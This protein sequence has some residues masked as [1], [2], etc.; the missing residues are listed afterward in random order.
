MASARLIGETAGPATSDAK[1]MTV[2]T[3]HIRTV[4]PKTRWK[5][6]QCTAGAQ[7]FQVLLSVELSQENRA[8]KPTLADD[9]VE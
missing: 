2:I 5:L 8:G 3:A 7:V 9:R 4:L 6:A 1:N